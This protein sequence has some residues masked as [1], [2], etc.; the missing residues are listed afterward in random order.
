[1]NLLKQKKITKLQKKIAKAVIAV[2]V[3]IIVSFIGVKV[4]YYI[5]KSIPSEKEI[6]TAANN[7]QNG[8]WVASDGKWLYYG[9]NGL[10]KMRLDDG[11]RQ[12]VILDDNDI[13]PQHMFCVG[14]NVFYFDA[15]KYHTLDGTEEKDLEFSIFTENCIQYD[16]K[17]FYVTGLGNYEENGIY[18]VESDNTDKF[19][20][21]S[22]ISPTRLLLQGDYLYAISG[23]GSVNYESNENYGTW[24]MD[25]DGKNAILILDY[26]PKYMVFSED[27]IYYTNED[28]IICSANL[29]GS[30]E[31]IFESVVTTDGLN[32]S[33]DYIFY[34]DYDTKRIC[35]MDK[36]GSNKTEINY[37]Q[38]DYLDVIE[39]WI[40]YENKDDGNKYYKMNFDGSYNEPMIE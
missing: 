21:I 13:Y 11:K 3:A 35:R 29:D 16:G 25:K 14:K 18:V 34:I 5:Q 31:T 22:D 6:R 28:N 39:D 20:K 32:V 24:R 30:D 19:T 9:N 4:F 2:A 26:C 7:L 37:N 38:S 12:S 10:Y 36:D 27:K 1:M 15:M 17:N 40:F 23:F 33:D 8:A